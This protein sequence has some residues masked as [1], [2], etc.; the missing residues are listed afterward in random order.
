MKIV[1]V[2]YR[3]LVS[4]PGFSNQAVE[5]EA[6][7]EEGETPEDALFNL[8]AWVQVQL[9]GGAAC[10]DV[11][12]LRVEVESLMRQRQQ[13]CVSVATA[14]AELQ[15]LREQIAEASGDDLDITLPF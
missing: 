12:A 13:L 8:S 2:R 5:A 7:L 6:N 14:R 11:E 1:A 9:N 4:G 10:V 3:K 15:N